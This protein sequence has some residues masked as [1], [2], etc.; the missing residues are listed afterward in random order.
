MNGLSIIYGILVFD[1]LHQDGVDL[2]HLPLSE[3]KCHL[4]RLCRRAKL[5]IMKQVQTFPDGDVLFEHCAAWGQ[6]R[7]TGPAAATRHG[8]G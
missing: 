7:S 5:P 3:R 1:L 8:C 6:N 4:D 2:R